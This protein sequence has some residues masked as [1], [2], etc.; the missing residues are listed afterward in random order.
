MFSLHDFSRLCCATFVIGFSVASLSPGL[1]QHVFCSKPC[2]YFLFLLICNRFWYIKKTNKTLCHKMFKSKL[3]NVND[4]SLMFAQ[5][6]KNAACLMTKT[7]YNSKNNLAPEFKWAFFEPIW[8]K[9]RSKIRKLRQ[10]GSGIRAKIHSWSTIYCVF[11]FAKPLDWLQK[12]TIYA[13]FKARWSENLF[14][15]FNK[16]GLTPP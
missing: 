11:K 1:A 15:P 12:N 14:T 5:I 8:S 10:A 16:D 6:V 13:L 4:R 2:I 7:Q 3:V 9:F